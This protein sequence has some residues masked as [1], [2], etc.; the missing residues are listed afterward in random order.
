MATITLQV[1]Q[2]LERGVL[3]SNLSVPLT[4]GREEE[5]SVQLNDER[6]SRCHVKIQQDGDRIILTDLEST[7]GTRVNGLPV[8]MTVLHPGDLISLGRCVLLYGSQTEIRE[9]C[10]ELHRR[11]LEVQC[12]AD[13]RTEQNESSPQQYWELF[14]EHGQP[15]LAFP[16]GR[17]RLPSRLS[18]SARS[19]LADLLAYFH[20]R[21]LLILEARGLN[22]STEDEQANH[23][24][25]LDSA[26]IPW[27]LW[28]LLLDL[29]ADLSQYLREIPEPD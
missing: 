17:P 3:H 28:Y 10:H 5:N 6:I 9:H 21:L 13:S 24:Q 19:E 1:L 25:P 27:P 8:Q 22:D 16:G 4:I 11:A 23:E 7:N 26:R 12:Q 20:S 14:D 18:L 2:G 29:E 15:T